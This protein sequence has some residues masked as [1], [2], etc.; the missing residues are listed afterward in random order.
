VFERQRKEKFD[1][2]TQMETVAHH[3]EMEEEEKAR[4]LHERLQ[5]RKRERVQSNIEREEQRQRTDKERK[6][7][8]KALVERYCADQDMAEAFKQKQADD[9][10]AKMQKN[11]ATG[12]KMAIAE[13]KA[14]DEHE[15][16]VLARDLAEGERKFLQRE[17][18]K[19]DT[20][21]RLTKEMVGT[22]DQQ[23]Y[24]KQQ[25]SIEEREDMKVRGKLLDEDT[26]EM[27]RQEQNKMY[28]RYLDRKQQEKDM[29]EQVNYTNNIRLEHRVRPDLIPMESDFNQPA[30]RTMHFSGYLD[31]P[32]E[33][34]NAHATGRRN[35]R[36]CP[37]FN[38]SISELDDDS[39]YA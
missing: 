16:K 8:E 29:I 2:K 18:D 11:T 5:E 14:K 1:L 23:V 19:V 12:S 15:A 10:W 39:V 4:L 6:D 17:Q 9:R 36:T 33:S 34:L 25:I 26:A 31:C 22:L 21:N 3:Y 37:S 13:K 30:L 28:K 7:H 24:Q 38:G 35:R 27:N 32:P 20:F